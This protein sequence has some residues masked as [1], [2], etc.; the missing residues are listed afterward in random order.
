V[1]PIPGSEGAFAPFFSPDGHSIAFFARQRLMTVSVDSGQPS[2]VAEVNTPYGGHWSDD[3]RIAVVMDD[4]VR[5]AVLRSGS[6]DLKIIAT[7]TGRTRLASPVWLPGGEWLLLGCGEPRHICAVSSRTGDRRHLVVDGP[8]AGTSEG[9]RLVRGSN[10]RFIA[11]GFLVYGA[12]SDNAVMGVRF[13]PATLTT[14]GEPVELLRGVRREHGSG[15][16]QLAANVGG[17]GVFAAG[18]NAVVGT[19]V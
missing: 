9:V 15:A 18:A 5:L 2:P 4:G 17:D 16:F 10:P 6:S 13:D 19:L 11:P 3:G 8:A 7:F 1:R 14:I 12:A